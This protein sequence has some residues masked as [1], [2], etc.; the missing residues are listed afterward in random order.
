M[1]QLC[2]TTHFR[3][4]MGLVLL[5]ACP[6]IFSAQCAGR[7]GQPGSS[8]GSANAT[9]MATNYPSSALNI[10]RYPRSSGLA[11]NPYQQQSILIQ[12]AAY[13]TINRMSMEQAQKRAAYAAMVRPFRLARA[14][15]NRAKRA[16]EIEE[17][18]ANQANLSKYVKN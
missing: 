7:G 4:L 17:R 6:T 8:T 16:A 10:L 18:K 15:A 3:R 5:F 1:A 9:R 2:K 13:A 14:Q 12:N 11:F